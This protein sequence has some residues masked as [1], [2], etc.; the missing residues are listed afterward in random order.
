VSKKIL[1]IGATGRVGSEL[2]KLLTQNGEVVRAVS[3]NPSTVLSKF[4]NT[5]EVVE[6]DYERPSTFAPALVGIEKVFL[7]VRPGDN[8]S[9]KAAM[10]L[11]DAAK[12]AKVQHIVAL[13]AM[14]VEQ[15]DTFMLRILEKYI[16]ESG[17]PYTHL[18]P[19]LQFRADVC[20]YS[21]NRG[22][23]SSSS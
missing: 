2:V 14:G 3:R 13:T 23:T 22:I 8:H 10:P 17:I 21:S 1:V 12:K 11:I 19:K 4:Q 5:V 18:R 20:R 6:F 15:D 16:E 9:D 7:T